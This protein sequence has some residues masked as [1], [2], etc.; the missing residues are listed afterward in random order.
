MMHPAIEI[1]GVKIHVVDRCGLLDAI[2][3]AAETGC[4]GIINNV[5]VHAMNLAY[6]DA[7]LREILNGSDLVFVDGAGIL[8][9]AAIAGVKVSERLTPAD[10]VHDPFTLCGAY[11][12]TCR[13]IR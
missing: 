2:S 6:C 1:L 11:P 5:N 7:E 12:I 13:P 4:G 8:L 9:G 3:R 10:W